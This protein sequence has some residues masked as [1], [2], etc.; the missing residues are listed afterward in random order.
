[1]LEDDPLRSGSSECGDMDC[2]VPAGA[3]LLGGV[4]VVVVAVELELV[5]DFSEEP[6]PLLELLPP[7]TGVVDGTV[8]VGTGREGTFGREGTLGSASAGRFSP[9]VTLLRIEGSSELR[10]GVLDVLVTSAVSTAWS[11]WASFDDAMSAVSAAFGAGLAPPHRSN[12]PT[13]EAAGA[14]AALGVTDVGADDA[15]A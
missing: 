5:L 6:A 1:M 7:I 3:E 13:D 15:A 14:G 10:L 9:L 8:V 11:L 4:V 12:A 2:A